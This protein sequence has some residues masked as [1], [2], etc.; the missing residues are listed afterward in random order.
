MTLAVAQVAP[1]TS[2]G[3]A[4]LLYLLLPGIVFVKTV[5]IARRRVATLSRFDQLGYVLAGGVGSLLAL[6]VAWRFLGGSALS[7]DAAFE[8]PVTV[9]LAGVGVQ[10]AIAA[11]MGYGWGSYR[12]WRSDVGP[13]RTWDDRVQPWEY[14]SEKLRRLDVVTVVRS[15]GTEVHGVVSRYGSGDDAP[16][17]VLASPKIRERV[18]GQVRNEYRLG[19]E[20]FLSADDIWAIHWEDDEYRVDDVPPEATVS[21]DRK[22]PA[23]DPVGRIPEWLRSG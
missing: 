22:S 20:A 15:D 1:E 18:D 19:N 6:V 13:P 9:L 5:M 4:A 3:L 23:I 10:S 8:R 2:T 7:V 21:L 16:A 12:R 17:L 11:A 14:T